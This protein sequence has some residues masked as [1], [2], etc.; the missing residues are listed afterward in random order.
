[1]N[2]TSIPP[3]IIMNK[4]YE[5]QKLWDI[6]PVMVEIRTAWISSVNPIDNGWDKNINMIDIIKVSIYSDWII[7]RIV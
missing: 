6:N 4:M 3:I 2:S 1:M 5:N 7:Q